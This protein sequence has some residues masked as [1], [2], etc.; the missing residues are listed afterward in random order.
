[1]ASPLKDVGERSV[2]ACFAATLSVFQVLCGISPGPVQIMVL[3][4][5]C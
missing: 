4:V 3:S 5:Q 1:M 2:A